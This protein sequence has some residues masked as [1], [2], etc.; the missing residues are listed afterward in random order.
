M[1]R[2][3]PVLVGVAAVAAS[4]VDSGRSTN[5]WGNSADLQAIADRVTLVRP[6]LG[7]WTS[8]PHELNARQLKVAGITNYISRQYSNRKTGAIVQVLLICGSPGPI[9]VHTPDI[10]YTSAGYG[11]AGQLEKVAV[12]SDEFKAGRFVKGS[13]NPDSLRIMWAWTTD[14][15]FQIPEN[16]RWAFGRATPALFKRY[17]I[18]QTGPHEGADKKDRSVEFLDVFLPELKR[19]LAPTS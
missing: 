1:M 14:G 3:L 9:S 2:F 6:E 15:H 7:D 5:R 10:C 18:R 16:P 11:Q 8:Q 19:C 13:P 17:V 12:G 4:A